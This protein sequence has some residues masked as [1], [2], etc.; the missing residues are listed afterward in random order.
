[1]A[2]IPKND[3]KPQ[4]LTGRNQPNDIKKL[5]RLKNRSVVPFSFWLKL[6]E[7]REKKGE[8]CQTITPPCLLFVTIIKSV[9]ACHFKPIRMLRL[10][11]NVENSNFNGFHVGS[12][13]LAPFFLL[14]RFAC[15]LL[16]TRYSR[17]TH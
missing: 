1:M 14:A 11:M 8:R 16:P 5:N 12:L 2:N 10:W 7:E 13:F 9:N 3:K 4:T 17:E 15:W 6:G